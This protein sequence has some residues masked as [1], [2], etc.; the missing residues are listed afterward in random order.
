MPHDRHA[1]LES[2]TRELEE[3]CQ[4]AFATA[5]AAAQAQA[6]PAALQLTQAWK[7]S[8]SATT[9]VEKQVGLLPA[10]LPRPR[11]TGARCYLRWVHDMN[12]RR[13]CRGART[14]GT[15]LI[16]PA[17]VRGKPPLFAH[18]VVH[19]RLRFLEE[20]LLRNRQ[21]KNAITG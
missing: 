16:S 19:G 5:T 3:R 6:R 8:K 15:D 7:D 13:R 2:S 12:P 18:F 10:R 17:E 21:K 20:T 4:S 11:S 14:V 1:Q 9:C